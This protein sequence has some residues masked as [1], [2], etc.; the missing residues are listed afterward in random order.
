MMVFFLVW[1]APG[2]GKADYGGN[3]R[4]NRRS[5]EQI[6]E[7]AGVIVFLRRKKT[8]ATRQDIRETADQDRRHCKA[9]A[10]STQ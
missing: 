2:E 7:W 4:K 10:A 3:L 6:R 1:F 5:N 8:A 9:A